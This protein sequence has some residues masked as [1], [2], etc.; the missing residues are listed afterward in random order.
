MQNQDIKQAAKKAGIPLWKL[1]EE[2]YQ[3]TDSSFSRKLRKEL[4]ESE[5]KKVLEAINCLSKEAT[6]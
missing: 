5:K 4:P 2:V 1:A 3:I 6:A